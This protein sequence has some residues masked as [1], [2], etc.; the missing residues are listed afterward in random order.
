MSESSTNLTKEELNQ[1]NK[2]LY[3]DQALSRALNQAIIRCINTSQVSPVSHI[4]IFDYLKQE[5]VLEQNASKKR[6]NQA[7]HTL[8]NNHILKRNMMNNKPFFSLN[9]PEKPTHRQTQSCIPLGYDMDGLHPNR[10]K[11][12]KENFTRMW[13]DYFKHELNRIRRDFLVYRPKDVFIVHIHGFLRLF[14]FSAQFC[15]GH[16]PNYSYFN[17]PI[18]YHSLLS[19]SL[20]AACDA[21]RS[22]GWYFKIKY[23]DEYGNAMVTDVCIDRLKKIEEIEFIIK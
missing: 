13:L 2:C 6:M 4:E 18:L 22:I 15:Q 16:N 5:N 10:F 23:K 12:N 11:I 21:M 8:V 1:A 20:V 3:K 14:D 19:E 17:E 9:K 7:L